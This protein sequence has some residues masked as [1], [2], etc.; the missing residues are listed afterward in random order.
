MP[1]LK[2]KMDG[3]QGDL[4]ALAL[5]TRGPALQGE[6]PEDDRH[7]TTQTIPPFST[8]KIQTVNDN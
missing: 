5:T 3:S 1:S 4:H 6:S 7:H 2:G 8:M